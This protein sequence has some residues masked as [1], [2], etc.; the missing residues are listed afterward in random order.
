MNRELIEDP[1]STP[2]QFPLYTK[3]HQPAEPPGI[4][5]GC[6]EVMDDQPM[7]A[8]D[9][10]APA[11]QSCHLLVSNRIGLCWQPFALPSPC[12]DTLGFAAQLLAVHQLG[13]LHR[14]ASVV[15]AAA[16]RHGQLYFGDRVVVWLMAQPAMLLGKL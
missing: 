4:S 12:Q 3:A 2:P 7:S 16:R 5:K 8:A 11:E 6:P 9:C 1:P 14:G 10:L 15:G 13:Q